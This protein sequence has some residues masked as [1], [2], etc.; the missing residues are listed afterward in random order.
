MYCFVYEESMVSA[1]IIDYSIIFL[2]KCNVV[3]APH[4]STW[5]YNGASGATQKKGKGDDEMGI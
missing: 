3:S 1:P 5:F 4:L 2:Q